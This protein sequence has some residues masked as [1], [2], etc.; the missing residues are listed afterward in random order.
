MISSNRTNIASGAGLSI[1]RT[2]T[3]GDGLGGDGEAVGLDVSVGLGGTAVGASVATF[4]GGVGDATRVLA[5]ATR[6]STRIV[7][8][9]V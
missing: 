3:S 8:R 4:A 9:T 2:V 7:D 1:L 5:Q 6:P